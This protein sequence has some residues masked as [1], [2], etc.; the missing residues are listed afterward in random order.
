MKAFIR[1]MQL[2]A[3]TVGNFGGSQ[4]VEWGYVKCGENEPVCP[5]CRGSAEVTMTIFP[6]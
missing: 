2:V 1:R 5:G 3:G 4:T 6:F